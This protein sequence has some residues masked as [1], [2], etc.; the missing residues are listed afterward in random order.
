MLEITRKKSVRNFN[1]RC[2]LICLPDDS[3]QPSVQ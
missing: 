1:G 2:F 3:V